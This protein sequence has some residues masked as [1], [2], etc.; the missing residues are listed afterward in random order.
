MPD[1]TPLPDLSRRPDA[2]RTAARAGVILVLLIIAVAGMCY[3]GWL[4]YSLPAKP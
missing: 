2:T 3:T 1:L 4:L